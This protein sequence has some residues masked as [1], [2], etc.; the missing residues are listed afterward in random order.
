MV[1]ICEQIKQWDVE[2]ERHGQTGMIAQNPGC[3][4]T[5]RWGR[6]DQE[7]FFEIQMPEVRFKEQMELGK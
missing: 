3:R 7:R 6:S 1:D 4:S 5:M 2:W